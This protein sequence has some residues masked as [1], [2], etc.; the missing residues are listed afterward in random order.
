ML[1]RP[2]PGRRFFVSA[3]DRNPLRRPLLSRAGGATPIGQLIGAALLVMTNRP[4]RRPDCRKNNQIHSHA[5]FL[6]TSPRRQ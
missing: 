1:R 2:V 4:I 6:T 5:Y 3:A